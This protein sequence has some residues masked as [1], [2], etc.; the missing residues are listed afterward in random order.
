MCGIYGVISKVNAKIDL[1]KKM[2]SLQIHRG[3]DGEG[4]YIDESVALGMRRLSII[5]VDKGGQPFFSK[6]K[7]IVV[8][9]N[10]E[11]YNY[12]E[13]RKELILLGYQFTTESDIEVLPYLY[14]E[15]GIDFVTKLNGMYAISLWDVECE[16]FYLIRDRMGVKPLYYSSLNEGFFYA[17]EM[18]SILNTE[19][20]K[21]DLDYKALSSFLEITYIPTPRTPFKSIKKL[22]SASYLKLKS[23]KFEIINYWDPKVNVDQKMTENDCLKEI[24][25]ILKDSI[26]HQLISDVPLGSFLSGGVDSSLITAMAAKKSNE[27]FSSFHMRWNNIKGKTD[28]SVF[29]NKVIEKYDLKNFTKNV[30]DLDIPNLLAKLIWHLDEPFGDAA[31]IPTYIL[32]EHAAKNV[33]VILS[34]AGGDE[35]FGGYTRYKKYSKIESIFGKILLNKSPAF[36]FYDINKGSHT[37]FWKN[38]FKWYIPGSA[39][40]KFD[41]LYNENKKEDKLN[42]YMLGDLKIYLQDNI[43]ALTDRMTSAASIECRVPLLDHRLVELSLKTPSKLKIKINEYKYI[44]KKYSE[45]YLDKDILYR[46]KEGFGSPVWT[47]IDKYRFSHF[48]FLLK[49]GSVL[50]EM[51]INHQFLVKIMNKKS[52]KY[53]EYWMYWHLLVL[54]IWTRIYVKNIPYQSIFKEINND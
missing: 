12:K 15:F 4:H 23:G 54:E 51:N 3:P 2:E 52:L 37:R 11:I 27:K 22:E 20:V 14:E 7:K 26:K 46:E 40:S 42:A 31:F 30:T 35:L 48:N 32:A 21:K 5:D 36:S 10:G 34:G 33:K 6:N 28:E 25:E 49:D 1:L 47:W 53:G 24:D 41:S 16:T 38:A 13:L 9:C 8:L 29:A 18:K 50:D 19:F 17:S 39:K 43:L 44:L 45:N